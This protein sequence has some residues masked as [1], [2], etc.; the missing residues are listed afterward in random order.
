MA[1]VDTGTGG[2]IPFIADF[3]ETFPARASSS[4]ASRVTSS[5]SEICGQIPITGGPQG[6]LRAAL[7]KVVGPDVKC[8]GESVQ[9]GVHEGL[10]AQRWGREDR[11]GGLPG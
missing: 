2:S 9:V 11:L 8:G 7:Q 4:L 10:Q 6:P 5:A 3:Q 1:P